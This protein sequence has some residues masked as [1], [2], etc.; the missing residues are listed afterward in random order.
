M[1]LSRYLKSFPDPERPGFAFLYSTRKGSLVRVSE[2]ML[3]AARDGSLADEDQDL[4]KRLEMWVDDPAAEREAMA[5]LVDQT[6]TR[7]ATFAAT[8]VLTLDCNLA[9]SYCFEDRFRA[10]QAM[11]AETARLL[12]AHVEKEQIGRGRDV[13]LR[14]YGGEPLMAVPRLKEIARPLRDA[15]AI[16]GTRFSCI[17]VTNATLLTRPVVEALLPFGLT[18][19]QITLDGPAEIHNRQRPFVS[20]QGSF[21]TIVDNLKAVHELIILKPGGNYT[22]ENYREFPAMLDALLEAG[23]D[24]AKVG[25]VQFGPVH[26][27]S[28]AGADFHTTCA[29]VDEPWL[30]EANLFLREETL[31]RG[32][33]VDKPHMGICMIE[34]ANTLVVNW[35][36]SL[37]KCPPLMGWPEFSV[38][39]LAEGIND[40][41]ESHNL[42]IWKNDECLE[43]AYLPLCFGGCRFYRKLKTGSLDGVDCR[44]AIW[45][46]SLERI[47]LQDMGL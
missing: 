7:S 18:S 12:V 8:V 17:L 22:R 2:Q 28:G 45:D 6:N 11:D 10:G 44:R 15:A 39:T 31:A 29:M 21:K 19:A 27:K 30:I 47:V 26:P 36:G 4:L 5:G 46:A 25:P 42:D 14:F 38:G 16:V 24:P 20:G 13:E 40:Y 41:R 37:Y 33:A 1:P 35:D 23:I 3:A 32:F 9:C 43:C 34:L